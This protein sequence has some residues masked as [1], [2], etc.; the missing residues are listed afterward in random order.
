M[1]AVSFLSSTVT[2]FPT[3]TCTST[4][5]S[6]ICKHTTEHMHFAHCLATSLSNFRALCYFHFYLYLI[7]QFSYTCCSSNREYCKILTK[8]YWLL[9]CKSKLSTNNK[10]L[11]YK[12][13]LKPILT[14]GTQPWGL[15][16]TFNIQILESFQTKALCMTVIQ[17]D[18]QTPTVKEEIHRY[19]SQYSACLSANPNDLVVNLVVQPYN[20]R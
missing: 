2:W 14:Y 6:Q 20:N 18:L 9:G 8:M 4:F 7:C 10:L 11:L 17:R 16:S 13:I 19:S 12:A 3:T 15:A 1:A 5:F